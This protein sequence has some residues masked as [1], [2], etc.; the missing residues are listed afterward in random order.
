[1]KLPKGNQT[2]IIVDE[3]EIDARRSKV[4]E[5][6]TGIECVRSGIFDVYDA[7][8]PEGRSDLIVTPENAVATMRKI[9]GLFGEDYPELFPDMI[10]HE[11]AASGQQ[12]T[13]EVYAYA[14]LNTQSIPD[15]WA[16]QPNSSSL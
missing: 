12:R 13:S 4:V 3:P 14:D 6:I 5:I 15:A 9:K 1:M 8:A 2:P 10:E 16:G 7:M 11:L